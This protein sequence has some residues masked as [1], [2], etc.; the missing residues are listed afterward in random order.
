[1]RAR[2]PDQRAGLA[3]LGRAVAAACTLQAGSERHT[4]RTRVAR[5]AVEVGAVERGKGL[6][7]LQ[8]ARLLKGV[9]VERE[10]DRRGEEA[11]AAARALL[12]VL[13]VRRCSRGGQGGRGGGTAAG[14][15][16]LRQG[17]GRRQRLPAPL[18][19]PQVAQPGSLPAPSKHSPESVPKK[20]LLLPLVAA[21]AT[22]C[23]CSSRFRMGRQKA[24]GRRPPTKSALR[25][26]RM[27]CE[28]VRAEGGGTRGGCE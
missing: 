19:R 5:Q 2:A 17:H 22:A 16:R 13:G 9:R 10:G 4:Q 25:L 7:V 6:Q 24:C 23:R 11:G 28:G 21:A 3:V 14:K 8:R 15:Y 1:M 12:G 20:N 18:C 26:S 27:C